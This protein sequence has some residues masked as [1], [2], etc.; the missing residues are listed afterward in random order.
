MEGRL[1]SSQFGLVQPFCQNGLQLAGVL[2]AE[3][4][5]LEAADRGL[6]ELGAVHGSQSLAHVGLRVAWQSNSW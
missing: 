2:E 6:A 3:L 1:T 4:Q 5:V